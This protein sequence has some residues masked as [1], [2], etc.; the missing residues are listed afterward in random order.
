VGSSDPSAN[1]DLYPANWV[2]KGYFL[3]LYVAP[4]ILGAFIVNLTRERRPPPVHNNR[5]QS[6]GVLAIWLS[7]RLEQ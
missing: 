5:V 2:A 3:S 1:Y 4:G 7:A 6:E